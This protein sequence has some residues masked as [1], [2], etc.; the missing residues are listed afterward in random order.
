MITYLDILACTDTAL[1]QLTNLLVRTHALAE[2][3]QQTSEL[4]LQFPNPAVYYTEP[5]EFVA[6]AL[7]AVNTLGE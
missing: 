3:R 7:I 4:G 1:G 5:C 6:R 2:V